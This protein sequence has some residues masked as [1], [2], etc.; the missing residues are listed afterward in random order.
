M[1]FVQ[2]VCAALAGLSERV[3]SAPTPLDITTEV[4]EYW[5]CVDKDL[6]Y[7][8][9]HCV[10]DCLSQ[11]FPFN[12][13]CIRHEIRDMSPIT[14]WLFVEVYS[15][16]INDD[17]LYQKRRLSLAQFLRIP[18]EEVAVASSYCGEDP[19]IKVAHILP[20]DSSD[21]LLSSNRVES[22]IES[23]GQVVRNNRFSRRLTTQVPVLLEYTSSR[24]KVSVSQSHGCALFDDGQ[25]KCYG[26]MGALLGLGHY[27]IG[28][29]FEGMDRYSCCRPMSSC[30]LDKLN[31]VDFGTNEVR[32]DAS[33]DPPHWLKQT[34]A[35]L[36]DDQ[37][38]LMYSD[39]SQIETACTEEDYC[40][41]IYDAHCDNLGTFHMC[42]RG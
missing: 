13:I 5:E 37:F 22:R 18:V 26:E 12:G 36:S 2:L 21:R 4:W 27:D 31:F 40:G 19:C 23:P 14:A 16:E 6:V 39:R 11:T 29:V 38:G 41:G 8:G 25:V 3:L 24:P 35:C 32:G 30:C 20:Q 17:V 1:L 7:V 34:G 15:D 33:N 28:D 9:G 42:N 10:M